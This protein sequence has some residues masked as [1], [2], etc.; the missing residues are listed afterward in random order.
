MV[1]S[2]NRAVVSCSLDGK[3][4]VIPMNIPFHFLKSL[5]VLI[6]RSFGIFSLENSLMS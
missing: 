2:L 3:V 4:K 6:V 1:D 5:T